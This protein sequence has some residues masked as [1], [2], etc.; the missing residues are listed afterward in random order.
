MD[1]IIKLKEILAKIEAD[2]PK[3]YIKD[4]Q[5]AGLRIRKDIKLLQEIGQQIRNQTL[6]KDKK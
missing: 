1:L 5:A 3:F 4:N 2:G 6:G